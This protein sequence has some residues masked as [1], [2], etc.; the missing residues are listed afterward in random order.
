MNIN[1]YSP[2]KKVDF[3]SL[4]SLEG[5][6][7]NDVYE[8]ICEAERLRTMIR[9]KE[10]TCFFDKKTA[11]L[12]TD[13]PQ[14]AQRIA[15]EKAAFY[16]GG[17]AIVVSV[18][19]LDNKEGILRN[20][21]YAARSNVDA[22]FFDIDGLDNSLLPTDLT[23]INANS[24]S[25]P[26]F[27]LSALLT[28]KRAFGSPSDIKV[29]VVEDQRPSDIS[30][31]FAKA[32]AALTITSAKSGFS[33]KDVSYLSQFTD[34]CVAGNSPLQKESDLTVYNS[35]S[36]V[37]LSQILAKEIRPK[38][39][40]SGVNPLSSLLESAGETETS[41]LAA[42]NTE[43]VIAAILSLISAVK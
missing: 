28:A 2:K 38:I 16:Y 7:N 5:V 30:V 13:K 43:D 3:R 27:A 41:F 25:G 20:V 24:L 6:L 33:Q 4:I 32:N 22:V 1:F 17:Q 21:V 11:V 35:F 31:A 39:I 18:N 15:F 36:P 12:F 10:K 26:V 19:A 23:I 8:I 29:C 14:G 9:L 42:V 40:L 37:L 34:V